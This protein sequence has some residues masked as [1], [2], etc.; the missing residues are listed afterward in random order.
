MADKKINTKVGCGIKT[1][2]L[3]KD[4]GKKEKPGK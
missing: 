1:R 2:P 3:S 4:R